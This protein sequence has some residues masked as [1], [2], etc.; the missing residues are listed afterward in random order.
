MSSAKAE[1]TYYEYSEP[2][3]IELEKS[4]LRLI[5]FYLPQFHPIIENDKFWGKGF[6]EWTNVSKAIPQFLG[7]YQP[8]LP[9]DL[10]F[11]NLTDVKVI[12]RQVEMAKSFGIS[13]FCFHY[14][15]FSGKR[16]L[17]KPLNLFLENKDLNIE[18]CICWANENWTR[19][20]D[21]LD[22]D[23]LLS[24]EHNSDDD[25]RIFSDW[26]PLFRDER[27]IKTP[28]GK[29]IVIIYRPSLLKNPSKTVA[30]WRN[31]AR[32]NGLPDLFLM[33]TNF[34]SQDFMHDFDALVEFPPHGLID[35]LK[36]GTVKLCG[37]SLE[38]PKSNLRTVINPNYKGNIVDIHNCFKS[39]EFLADKDYPIV[40]TVFPSWDNEARKPGRGTSFINLTP[41]DF[42]SWLKE[43]SN[44]TLQLG[45]K[46]RT[47]LV[48]I[49]AWNEWAE[50]AHLEPDQKYGFTFLNKVARVVEDFSLE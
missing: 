1:K 38:E 5:A 28:D 41:N 7:H 6:T 13:G 37:E 24:Q 22:D 50:G 9:S 45:Y 39:K 4:D 14:Y 35:F 46:N 15:W 40:R 33:T 36:D 2:L 10:G 48:F 23:I 47:R 27:Y 34:A 29:P 12:E 31:L 49:N 16:V 17:E 11:Y 43:A 32:E 3:K 18:F 44:K 8:H 42:S 20:W 21:G 25:E 26:L 19:K 30:R